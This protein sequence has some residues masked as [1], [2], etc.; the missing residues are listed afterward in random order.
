MHKCSGGLQ[1][2][3]WDCMEKW[4]A[5]SLE[6]TT[7][8]EY[9][10]MSRAQS[11][12]KWD[13]LVVFDLCGSKILLLCGSIPHTP[14]PHWYGIIENLFKI[15]SNLASSPLQR[16]ST[17]TIWMIGQ[18]CVRF[19]FLFEINWFEYFKMGFIIVQTRLLLLRQSHII[20]TI[21]S[22]DNVYLFLSFIIE[23][24]QLVVH[25]LIVLLFYYSVVNRTIQNKAY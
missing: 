16:W 18:L 15:V 11:V 2:H 12:L 20:S 14:P 25:H 19:P 7:P 17:E 23:L 13:R 10:V 5:T 4:L 21:D 9:F 8:N 24:T 6:I 22:L 1:M 3:W